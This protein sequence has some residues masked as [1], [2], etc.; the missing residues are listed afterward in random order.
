VE[1]NAV[2]ALQYERKKVK[3]MEEKFTFKHG[4]RRI[5]QKEL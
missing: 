4:N 2:I 1:Q 3:T 5:F